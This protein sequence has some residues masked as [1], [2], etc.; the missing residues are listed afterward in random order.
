MAVWRWMAAGML[1]AAALGLAGG[2]AL[3]RLEAAVVQPSADEW[4]R[5]AI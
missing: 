5:G 3:A 2:Y 4:V 1:V